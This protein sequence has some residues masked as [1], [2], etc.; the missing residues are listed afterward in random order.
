MILELL[1]DSFH[2]LKEVNSGFFTTFVCI[3]SLPLKVGV[4]LWVIP[5]LRTALEKL[6]KE[7]NDS[8][9]EY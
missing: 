1:P 8:E 9:A 7:S 5:A 4:A 3:P 2:Q 6:K